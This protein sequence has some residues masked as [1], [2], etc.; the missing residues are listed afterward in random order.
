MDWPT[1]LTMAKTNTKAMTQINTKTKTF[2]ESHQTKA[3]T[4]VTML[5]FQTI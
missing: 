2:R 3:K 5:T 1:K 4:C